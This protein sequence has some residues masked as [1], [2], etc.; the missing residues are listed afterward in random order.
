MA[1]MPVM[2]QS[3]IK[4]PSSSGGERGSRTLLKTFN[5]LPPSGLLILSIISIQISSVLAVYLFP[6]IGPIGAAF[7]CV[8]F[9]AIVLCA[10]SRPPVDQTIYK[11]AGLILLFGVVIGGNFL[12]FYKAIERIPLAIASTIEFIG[13]LGIAIIFSRRL[14]DFLWVFLAVAGVGLITPGIG[15]QLD[16]LG[17]IYAFLSAIGW[18]GFVL[19]SQ[20]ASNIFVGNAGLG[21]GMVAATLFLLP[22]AI[23]DGQV[24]EVQPISL[25][26]AFLVALLS[27][28]IPL[29]LEFQALKRMSAR[30]YGVL[31]TLEPTAAAMAGVIFLGQD[32][33]W[34]TAAAV[35]CVTLAALGATLF[36]KDSK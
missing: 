19:I 1:N 2:M 32:I 24:Y 20:R 13:P 33:E 10:T 25:F 28:M 3:E 8:S 26:G 18:A 12:F 15:T 6:L 23:M 5:T 16:P 22:F 11:H 34:Q 29:S 27:T 30:T 35:I 17:V 36:D 31:V 9:S 7:L 14:L 4:N 21:L